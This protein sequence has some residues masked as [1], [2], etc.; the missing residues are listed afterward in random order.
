MLEKAKEQELKTKTQAAN[1]KVKTAKV[2]AAI[3][4]NKAIHHPHPQPNSNMD[5]E[6]L[7]KVVVNAVIEGMN[8]IKEVENMNDDSAPAKR[9]ANDMIHDAKKQAL[10]DK[11]RAAKECAKA[12]G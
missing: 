7:S 4:K 11:V 3:E 1:E 6:T 9:V 12:K 10:K 2:K 8:K 5:P